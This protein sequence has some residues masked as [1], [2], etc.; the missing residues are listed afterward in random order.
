LAAIV[1]GEGVATT[2][3]WYSRLCKSAARSA[4]GAFLGGLDLEQRQ[5]LVAGLVRL[6]DYMTVVPNAGQDA[7]ARVPGLR[8]LRV[9]P[10]RVSTLS[11]T[12]EGTT[13]ERVGSFLDRQGIAVRAGH[14]CA[15]PLL[16]H[17]GLES[18]VRASIALDNTVD[19]IDAL[20][21][22]LHQGLRSSWEWTHASPVAQ[23]V[24]RLHRL[25]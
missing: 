20:A 23:P 2:N 15:Q 5:G 12:I 7:L 13:S 11:F 21:E 19:D 16:R 25:W 4:S 14:H 18:A 17:F 9:A 22:V 6:P 24:V 8:L 3:L 1:G 10:G